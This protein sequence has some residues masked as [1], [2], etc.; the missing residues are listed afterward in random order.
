[1]PGY[2]LAFF[3]E[4]GMILFFAGGFTPQACLACNGAAISRDD[5][6]DLFA[7]IGTFYGPGDGSTTFNLPLLENLFVV[8]AGDTYEIGD[9]GGAATVNLAE[10]EMPAHQHA[11]R[12]G[13]NNAAYIGGGSGG[14]GV[15]TFV[16]STTTRLQTDIC[17]G[18]VA[19]E[20]RPPFLALLPVIVCELSDDEGGGEGE[21]GEDDLNYFI[22]LSYPSRYALD[23]EFEEEEIVEEQF[24][25]RERKG[26]TWNEYLE[27]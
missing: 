18:G 19:H 21:L 11:Q 10:E 2:P 26:E 13:T 16:R 24:I 22:N 1:M 23:G 5:Y 6:A 27:P 4:I 3:M 12:T 17:G 9:T 8:G 20:N 14:F 25:F 15:D 7:V